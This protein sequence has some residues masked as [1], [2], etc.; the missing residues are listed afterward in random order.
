[1]TNGFPSPGKKTCLPPDN[2][3]TDVNPF[4]DVPSEKRSPRARKHKRHF[5]GGG[6]KQSVQSFVQTAGA[7][8]GDA[9]EGANEDEVRS[10]CSAAKTRES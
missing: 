1:M 8:E 9:W 6:I 5:S 10:C 4:G 2:T 3:L 7:T